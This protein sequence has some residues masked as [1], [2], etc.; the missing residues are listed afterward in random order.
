MDATIVSV[1]VIIMMMV[2]DM[3]CV[4]RDVLADELD[5]FRATTA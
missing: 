3:L 4:L 2:C 5:T 1:A